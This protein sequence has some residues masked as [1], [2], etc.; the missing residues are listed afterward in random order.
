VLPLPALRPPIEIGGTADV[1]LR[2]PAEIVDWKTGSPDLYSPSQWWQLRAYG[3]A[4]GLEIGAA[5]IQLSLC[6]VQLGDRGWRHETCRVAEMH[7]EIQTLIAEAMH[8]RSLPLE[9]RRY[10]VDDCCT[11]CPARPGCPART[12]DLRSFLAL[13][14][15]DPKRGGLID[16]E[17]LEQVYT[18]AAEI[19]RKIAQITRATQAAKAACMELVQQAGGSFLCEDGSEL[20]VV[21]VAGKAVAYERKPYRYLRRSR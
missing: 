13:E 2:D 16:V 3:V 14:A 12:Q 7:A 9:E 5:E 8:Q 21:E 19:D 20:W 11:Y 4:Y 1:V 17:N 15:I 18:R 10:R 6:Y